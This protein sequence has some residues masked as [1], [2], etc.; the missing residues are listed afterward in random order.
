MECYCAALWPTNPIL[1]VWKD[2]NPLSMNVKISRGWQHFTDRFCPHKITS[3]T[4]GLFSNMRFVL[5]LAVCTS[6]I[7][8]KDFKLQ[9]QCRSRYLQCSCIFFACFKRRALRSDSNVSHFHRDTF[10][11]QWYSVHISDLHKDCKLRL[12]FKS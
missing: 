1:S 11:W 10:S 4:K 7:F 9:L 3:F 6:L 12:Q 8:I 2:L 5:I